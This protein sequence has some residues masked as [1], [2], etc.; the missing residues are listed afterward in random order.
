MCMFLIVAALINAFLQN[1]AMILNSMLNER[2][3][4]SFEAI[5]EV[6]LAIQLQ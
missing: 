3:D 5:V 2:H 6:H 4:D 1:C